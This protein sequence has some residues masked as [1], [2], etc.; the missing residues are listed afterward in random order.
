ML[1]L[2][3]QYFGHLM[4]RAD[5]LE[6]TLMLG[7]I[8]GRRRRGQQRMRCCCSI[9][10]Q[11]KWVWAIFRRWRMTG[12]PGV[13]QFTE[14]QNQTWQRDWTTAVIIRL[15]HWAFPGSSVG[16]DSACSAGDPGSI[17]GFGRSP[18]EGKGFLLQYFS[19]KNSMDCIVH[20]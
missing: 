17:P 11:W 2:K 7:K 10:I 20:E 14:V 18:G 19:L 3:L 9:P 6:K 12:K 13:L 16:K 5:S 8:K 15:Q 1:K 4:D